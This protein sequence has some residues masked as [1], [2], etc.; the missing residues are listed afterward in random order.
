MKDRYSHTVRNENLIARLLLTRSHYDNR[1][2]KG[3]VLLI[4]LENLYFKN[5]L[6]D[7][8]I[9]LPPGKKSL[10][11]EMKTYERQDLYIHGEEEIMDFIKKIE[12]IL[13]YDK[14]KS[15]STTVKMYDCSILD[16][17]VYPK[18][19]VYKQVK[20][21]HYGNNHELIMVFDRIS[22]MEMHEFLKSI[23]LS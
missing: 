14:E 6:N 18:N 23:D 11:N 8:R 15:C 22:L 10:T 9:Y 17:S 1:K 3:W 7:I 4:D 16:I 21:H 19:P 5:L 13:S 12:N 20:F 2:D